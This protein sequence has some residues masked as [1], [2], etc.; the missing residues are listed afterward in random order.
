[1]L[2]V[3]LQVQMSARGGSHKRSLSLSTLSR[4]SIGAGHHGAQRV[5]GAAFDSRVRSSGGN[6]TMLLF[7]TYC[8]L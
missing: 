4:P 8:L 1:M 2:G 7:N 6:S 3:L 5:S